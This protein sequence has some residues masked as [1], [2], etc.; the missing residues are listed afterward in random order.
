MFLIAGVS[1]ANV[2]M[3]TDQDPYCNE[4]NV[5]GSCKKC[6]FR[7]YF[8]QK[9]KLCTQVSDFCATWDAKT[10]ACLTCYPSYGSPVK[11]VCSANPVTEVGSGNGECD[12]NCQSYND[13]RQCIKCFSGYKLND[14]YI[15][16][17]IIVSNPPV[18]DHCAKYTYV[19][20]KGKYYLKWVT[21]CKAVCVECVAGYYLNKKAECVALPANC[22]VADVNGKCTDCSGDYVLE[23][24]MCVQTVVEQ[25]VD[26]CAEYGYLDVKGKWW[27]N[28]V[29]GCK[30]LCKKC[31]SGFY[32]NKSYVCVAFPANCNAVDAY[33][34]CTECATGYKVTTSGTCEKIIVVAPADNCAEYG[35]VDAKG[36]FYS[37]WV[38]GCKKVCVK[39]NTGY[40][41][42]AKYEC[43]PLT[44]NC[45]AADRNGKC[46]ECATGYKANDKGLCELI[47]VVSTGDNCKVYGYIDAK[48]KWLA[49]YVAGCKKVCKE[50][51]AGF[52]LVDGKCVEIVVGEV[53]ENPYCVERNEDG[54]CCG[55]AY[56]TYFN[57]EGI[58]T[59]VSDYCQEWDYETGTCTCCYVGYNLVQGDCILA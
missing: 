40:Y 11:G 15:C 29:S 24:G 39:C 28:W 41:I 55:C 23:N 46:T 51:N 1:A 9:T 43:N 47:P 33:G 2:R 48:G 22:D 18:V 44:S 36:K 7:Y 5:D 26:N 58:C 12:L 57:E 54:E 13:N 38:Q 31:V 21:G 59:P 16:I 37:K 27:G 17:E 14:N 20:A 52:E 19:D 3:L 56:R 8:D 25:P 4:Y 32:L 10:G 50:C 34:K 30:R 45:L 35:Y 53:D 42:N 49:K 6:S